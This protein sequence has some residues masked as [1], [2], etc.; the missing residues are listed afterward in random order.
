MKTKRP[1]DQRE[2]DA[3]K[4]RMLLTELAYAL[5]AYQAKRDYLAAIEAMNPQARYTDRV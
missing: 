5:G 4:A 1:I 3:A 2:D